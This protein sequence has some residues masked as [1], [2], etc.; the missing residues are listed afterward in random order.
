MKR[1]LLYCVII[2]ALFL[3]SISADA[4]A[5]IITYTPATNVLSVGVPFA[6]GPANTG[7]AVPAT[8]YGT[9]STFL[10]SGTVGR[11]NG[12]GTATTFNLP[13]SIAIDAAGN[14]YISDAGNNE[15]RL[16]TTAGV[17]TPLAGS[18]TGASGLTNATG[19]SALFNAPYDLTTDPS[20]NLYIADFS[21]NEI[22]KLT[23]ATGAVSLL[24]GSPSGA[25]GMAN[26]NTGNLA[27]FDN[28]PGIVYNPVAGALFVTDF[29]NNQIRK[30]T[31]AGAVTIFAGSTTGASGTGTGTGTAARF[32]GPNGIAVDA[33]GNM[34]V[35]DQN[36]NEIKKM[37]IA[38]VVTPLAG[39]TAGTA[40]TADGAG[41]AARFS[42][43][44]GITVDASGN[45]Y[46][47][48]SGNNTLRLVTPA[49][50]VTTFAG[51]GNAAYTDGVGIA[52]EFNQPRGLDFDPV[53][54]N[55]YIADYT[56][57]VIRKVITT[58][59]LINAPLP[60]GLSFDN[61]T[62]IIT[63]TP[64]GTFGSTTYTIFAFNA[65]GGAS[66]TIT[67]SCTNPTINRWDGS[68][69][70]TW[71]TAA[72]WSANHA[73][74]NTETA[75]IGVS[76]YV[77]AAN[78]PTVTG[79]I[80]VKTIL[81]GP[82]NAP[83]LTIASGVTLTVLSGVAVKAAS[84]ANINGPGTV[85]ITGIS[86]IAATGSLTAKSNTVI[87]LAANSQLTNSGT[88]TLASDINGSSSITAI[89]ATSRVTGTISVQRY[90]TGG[91]ATSRG[92][93]LLSSPVNAGSGVY[94]INYLKNS[95][96]LTGTTGAGGGFDQGTNPTLYLY[97]E[98]L[99]PAYTT[100]LNSNYIGISDINSA[101]TYSM[102]DATYPTT[103]IPEGNGYLCFFRGSRS[104]ASPYLTNTTALS[105]TLTAT[106]TLNQGTIVVKD[107]FVGTSNLSYTLASPFAVRG[108]NLVGNPYASSIDWDKF[109]TGITSTGVSSTMYILNP[110][111]KAY[112]LYTAGSGGVATDGTTSANIIPSGQGFFVLA[113]AASPTLTFTEAAKIST[114]QTNISIYMG[115]P[116]DQVVNKQYLH[117]QLAKD[118]IST[119][120]IQINLSNSVKNRLYTPTVDAPYKQGYGAVNLSSKSSDNVDLSINYIPL[121]NKSETV[122]LSVNVSTD[123]IYMLNLK[124]IVGIPQLFDIWLKDA[125]KKDSLDMKHNETYSFN[126]YKSDTTSFGSSRFSLVIRQNPAYAYHLLDFTA[127]KVQ[128]ATQVQMVWKTENEQNYT[129]FTVERSI[130]NGKT[131]DVLG[132]VDASGLGTYSLLDKNPISGQNLYRLKQEDINNAISYS[133]IVS[134]S[135]SNL[136][137][138][139]AVSNL[140][141]YPNP[142]ISI[143]NLAI[144]AL[145]AESA[146]YSIKFMNSSGTIAK[147]VSSSQPL[148]QGNV[149]NLLPGTYLIQVVNN[150]NQS[151]VGEAKLV[152]L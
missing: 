79:N 145:P 1:L 41:A 40:G 81:F 7:G 85:N 33:A 80:T 48:D 132:S 112:R 94:S 96:F 128:N 19:T 64:T 34:Y 108:F 134:V 61:T 5:P 115:Q 53:T 49:G 129:N 54:G 118:S 127:N 110:I 30:V 142:A 74:T 55:L 93:R 131:F 18:P 3:S 21:N 136:S 109:G 146:S 37:T 100:F 38:G 84:T 25:N 45:L 4:Q 50:L 119:D 43:P 16:S 140:S 12:T 104:T 148:W 35:S 150:K 17:V 24:A 82:L 46:I 126:I 95:T 101:P 77:G 73:P 102:N 58:G 103:T 66:T 114:Q 8:V 135:Y 13:R 44:R 122:V 88:F 90:I 51:S 107:W 47:T 130:D 23:I 98:N 67:L 99:T 147:E 139:I 72:N 11:A 42:A 137:N 141:I 15:I 22:R 91:A 57:N 113:T 124:N 31:L 78:Q 6:L 28:P 123:G 59:Y 87:T 121:P 62:G 111:S 133:N 36:N 68:S 32:N 116:A 69:S 63:G 75:E 89:P 27:T 92:Y 71:S 143:I 83:T 14:H 144:T 151:I 149:S 105:T 29:N 120:D 20:G 2:P 106:G 86:A 152:K 9:V 76:A 97:R 125:Y 70:S 26:N 65:T 39:S 60:A 10:G 138:N 117:L 56:N 52:A